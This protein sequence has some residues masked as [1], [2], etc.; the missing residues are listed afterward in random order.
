M[1]EVRRSNP[2]FGKKFTVTVQ[3]TKIKKMPGMDLFTNVASL[4][5]NI[6]FVIQTPPPFW[7]FIHY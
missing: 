5:A 6:T 1:P 3:K 2:V 4:R 7:P